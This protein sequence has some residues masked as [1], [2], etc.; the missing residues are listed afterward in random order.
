MDQIQKHHPVKKPPEP[1]YMKPILWI[2]CTVILFYYLSQLPQHPGSSPG[3]DDK[4]VDTTE[5]DTMASFAESLLEGYRNQQADTREKYSADH[6][7]TTQ[8]LDAFI[9]GCEDTSFDNGLNEVGVKSYC[10]CTL[11]ETITY[12]PDQPPGVDEWTDT[13]LLQVPAMCSAKV[14]ENP[15]VEYTPTNEHSLSSLVDLLIEFNYYQPAINMLRKIEWSGEVDFLLEKT[16]LNYGLHSMNTFD[17]EEM[18]ARMNN[19]LT[20]FTEVLKINPDNSIAR[21]Q[22]EQIMGVYS[23]MTDGGPNNNVLEGLRELGFDY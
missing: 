23:I 8:E 17:P 3:T 11:N 4:Q 14:L 10:K 2:G 6:S 18:N 13:N 15:M 12:Y 5:V 7:W 1:N 16:H 9:K 20:Q 22:I 19:A 21:E